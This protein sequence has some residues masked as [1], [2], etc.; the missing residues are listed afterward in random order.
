[1]FNIWVLKISKFGV[2]T[3]LDQSIQPYQQKSKIFETHIAQNWEHLTQKKTLK[4]DNTKIAVELLTRIYPGPC[5]SP[6][7]D[8]VTI[9]ATD[10]FSKA[11]SCHFFY[12]WS[13]QAWKCA[14]ETPTSENTFWHSCWT[15]YLR[16]NCAARPVIWYGC[17]PL[18]SERWYLT[19][20]RNPELSLLEILFRN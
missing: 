20:W 4:K 19:I 17:A 18:S 13:L 6:H 12:T 5:K 16:R 7:L 9:K 11:D 8:M 15:H 2:F 1:M 14:L 10:A 3:T